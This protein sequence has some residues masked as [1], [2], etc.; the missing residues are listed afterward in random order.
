M[1]TSLLAFEFAVEAE[2]EAVEDGVA[3]GSMEIAKVFV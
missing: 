2:E 3:I 1:T